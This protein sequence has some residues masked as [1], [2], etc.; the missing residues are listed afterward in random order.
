MYLKRK[1]FQRGRRKK[2]FSY[3]E[4]AA[5]SE[6]RDV[7]L[8]A[9]LENRA[10]P[11]DQRLREVYLDETYIHHHYRRDQNSIYD[12]ND[13]QDLMLES[14]CTGQRYSFAAAIQGR[15]YSARFPN[16][17]SAARIV[18]GSFWHFVDDSQ[19]DHHKSFNA[20]SFSKWF[21]EQLL[22]N[23]TK[24]SLIIMDSASCHKAAPPDAPD[25]NSMKKAEL[26]E[27]LSSK[28][29]PMLP[30]EAVASL[31]V[32]ARD[33]VASNVKDH[34]TLLAE[35]RGHKVLY[36]PPHHSELQPI[37][38]LWAK[39]KGD[40]GRQYNTNTTF[41]MVHERLLRAVDNASKDFALIER[42]IGHVDKAVERF[43]SEDIPS[44]FAGL[45]DA[46]EHGYDEEITS[47]TD[48]TRCDS[49][50]ALDDDEANSSSGSLYDDESII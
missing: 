10:R 31:R 23:L 32:K 39:I 17:L 44:G 35:E 28:G 20:D 34:C 45:W 7:Y 25:P 36:L 8:S 33:W 5:I 11:L 15:D 3:T 38:M 13:E 47:E 18:P 41:A 2:G 14:R 43:A 24:P 42:I 48:E 12:P 40:V 50:S 16:D 19:K 30:G 6:R 26:L 22:A 4:K 37:E 29:V 9:L 49:E 21:K 27:F 46:E 1:G